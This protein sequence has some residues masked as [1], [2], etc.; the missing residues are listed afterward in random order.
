MT[1]SRAHP[2][3]SK[4]GDSWLVID[5][6]NSTPRAWGGGGGGGGGVAWCEGAARQT[7]DFLIFYNPQKT[8]TVKPY[9][10]S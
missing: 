7:F 1:F 3:D 5:K 9:N 2:L 10:R 6:Y 8:R 4:Y